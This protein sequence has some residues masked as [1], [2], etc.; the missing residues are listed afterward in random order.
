[1]RVPGTG[2]RAHASSVVLSR[3]RARG[4]LAHRCNATATMRVRE[5]EGRH[6]TGVRLENKEK[7]CVCVGRFLIDRACVSC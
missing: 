1:M 7:M 2:S 3:A 4:V 6:G 5:R